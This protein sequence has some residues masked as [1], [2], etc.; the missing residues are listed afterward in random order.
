LNVDEITTVEAPETASDLAPLT[1]KWAKLTFSDIE[2][3]LRLHDAGKTQVEIA[4][5]IGCSQTTVSATLAKLK[6]TPETVKALMKGETAGVLTNWR[7][8]A[9]IAAKRGDHRPA[10]E[11]I[12]AAHP[13]LRPTQGNSAGGGGVVINIGAPGQPLSPPAIDVQVVS[14]SPQVSQVSHRLSDDS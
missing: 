8:A 4:S 2:L 11:W 3:L 14:L 7:K 13:E 1:S 5:V 10:R 9:R 6:Q 12:E